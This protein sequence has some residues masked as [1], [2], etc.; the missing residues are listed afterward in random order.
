MTTLTREQHDAA[1]V[2]GIVYLAAMAASM[3][4]EFYLREPLFVRNDA[5][6]TAINIVAN[7]RLFRMSAVIHLIMCSSDAIMA[8]ALYTILKP[9][10][11]SLAMLG[12]FWRVVDC[13]ILAASTVND[14]AALRLLSGSGYVRGFETVQLQVLARLFLSLRTFGFQ[15]AFIFLGLGSAVFAYLWLKSRYIPRPLAVLGIFASS[16]MAIV[17]LMT[18]ALPELGA[19]IG[20]SYMAPMFFFEVGMGI[21][22]LAKGLREPAGA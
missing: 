16:V 6:Q 13:V 20:V 3:F 22:L 18:I 17:G 8:A 21:W 11:R 14:L 9:V 5:V 2:V 19:R 15:I 1:K 7:E 4:A 12:A 10:N